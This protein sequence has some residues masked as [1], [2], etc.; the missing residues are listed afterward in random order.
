MTTRRPNIVYI[1]CHDLGKHLGCFGARVASP[2][3]DAFA[4]R[5]VAF[6]HAFCNAPACSPSR[7]C[8][9]TGQYSHTNGEIGL[10]HMG[11]SLAQERR[12]VV[13]HLNEHGYETAHF[14][15][16]HF[17]HAG[18]SRYQIDNERDW[19]D[20]DAA[21][22]VDDAV[23]F[24]GSRTDSETPFYM[25]VGIGEVHASRWN[26]NTGEGL[27]YGPAVPPEDVYIRDDTPDDPLTRQAF[28]KFQASIRYM[29]THVG[30]LFAAIEELGFADDTLV[31]F[32]TDH[33][34]ADLRSKG[35][36]YDRGVEIALLV[37]TPGRSRR[38]IV[39]DTLIQN[40]DY[41]PTMLDAAG[42]PVPADV[43]GKSFWPLLAGGAYE[44][45]EHLFIE[46]NFHGEHL[47]GSVEG[48]GHVDMY[49]PVRAVR[50]KHFHYLRYFEPEKKHRAWLADE[51]AGR[52][53]ADGGGL[54][55]LWPQRTEPREAEELFCVT[56]DP[57][58]RVNLAASPQCARIK[59]ELSA[60]LEEWMRRT[61]D[62]VLR[63]APQE[64]PE[65]PGWDWS[66]AQKP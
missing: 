41:V 48:D 43:Q 47:E 4:A 14:G 7:A 1:V 3:L 60:L 64:R 26:A 31:V 45:H 62:H 36:L 15:L 42:I 49:D 12:T 16:N 46:R 9:M 51:V 56:D 20:W 22:A 6:T 57:Q 65:E 13:D 32:T 11:W 44:P 5:G 25:N 63:G 18:T 19:E 35:T 37:Q 54:D 61:D 24:L 8:A 27:R 21:K 66:H 58:E 59:D 50:T 40:I 39:I 30:R 38:D 55:Y 10:S 2:N 28:G 29:D 23:A 34:I 53:H 33:G 17:R 52:L